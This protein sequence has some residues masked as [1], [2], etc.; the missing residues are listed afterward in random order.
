M[1]Q[2]D[3]AS[4]IPAPAFHAPEGLAAKLRIIQNM[5]TLLTQPPSEGLLAM[6]SEATQA[7]NLTPIMSAF[8]NLMAT[9]Q[10]RNRDIAY[11]ILTDMQ[12]SILAETGV[13]VPSAVP[14]AMTAGAVSVADAPVLLATAPTDV[15]ALPAAPVEAV[16]TVQ[17]YYRPDAHESI[18][19]KFPREHGEV[20]PRTYSIVLNG[21]AAAPSEGRWLSSIT[22]LVMGVRGQPRVE[23]GYGY[24]LPLFR[25]YMPA[26]AV[27]F[28][29][30]GVT[31]LKLKVQMSYPTA[32]ASL[33][34]EGLVTHDGASHF[35]AMHEVMAKG[36]VF[37]LDV[38][39]TPVGQSYMAQ[40]AS[41]VLIERRGAD[42]QLIQFDV[43][44]LDVLK[45]ALSELVPLGILA[46]EQVRG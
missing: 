11:T 5:R 16:Q 3:T 37:L 17:P 25:E 28:N 18:T 4:S 14:M 46:E 15:V 44:D 21:V 27:D 23:H 39:I 34:Y 43:R 7:P 41:T 30:D 13:D 35:F 10:T 26:G 38:E 9:G 33:D 20:E 42:G 2:T 1:S 12:Q 6:I 40:M 36:Y 32:V 45:A 24:V 19:L 29:P 22:G 8:L 31:P